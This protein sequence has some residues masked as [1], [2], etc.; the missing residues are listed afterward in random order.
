MVD[1]MLLKRVGNLTG[2]NLFSFFYR[3]RKC[4]NEAGLLPVENLR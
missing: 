4:I 2:Q 1:E 3:N